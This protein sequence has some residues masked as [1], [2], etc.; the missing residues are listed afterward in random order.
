MIKKTFIRFG[1][2]IGFTMLFASC[3]KSYLVNYTISLS[4]VTKPK[5]AKAP[6]GSYDVKL[7]EEPYPKSIEGN[8]KGYN[9]KDDILDITW[10]IGE[11]RFYF[12]LRNVSPY[13]IKINWDDISFVDLSG[14]AVKVVHSGIDKNNL[15]ILQPPITIP[16]GANLVDELIPIKPSYNIAEQS[17]EYR[18]VPCKYKTTKTFNAET[19]AKYYAGKELSIMMPVVIENVQNDYTFTFKVGE[20]YN[21]TFVNK[22]KY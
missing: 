13:T 1:L 21:V 7:V 14:K 4:S 11:D 5:D 19:G 22:K 8:M 18:L 3:S 16:Q 6:Y 12:V 9:Y 15:N 2:L 17:Y 10:Y 20:L